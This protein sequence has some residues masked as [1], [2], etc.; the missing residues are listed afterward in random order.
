VNSGRIRVL[1]VDDDTAIRQMLQLA[2]AES[3]HDVELSDG[4]GTVDSTGIDVIVMDLRLGRRTAFDLLAEQPELASRPLVLITATSDRVEVPDSLAT[5][6]QVLRK[7]FDLETL[8][9]AIR[10]AL[11]APT[12]STPPAVT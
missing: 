2:L 8:E 12:R 7:P 4:R 9:R 10:D 3:G 6:A 5:R 11:E 1:V